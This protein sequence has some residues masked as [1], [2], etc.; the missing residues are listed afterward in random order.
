VLVRD[1]LR[2]GLRGGRR[3]LL[4]PRAQALDGDSERLC[5]LRLRI[6][7][8]GYRNAR[9]AGGGRRRRPAEVAGCGRPGRRLRG[10]GRGGLPRHRSARRSRCRGCDRR[11]RLVAPHGDVA[12]PANGL[13][14]T[15]QQRLRGALGAAQLLD[16]ALGPRSGGAL[17]GEQPLEL[18]CAMLELGDA[19]S[20]RRLGARGCAAVGGGSLL[21]LGELAF[22]GLQTGGE[23]LD[24]ALAGAD[25]TAQPLELAT[26]LAL[27][28]D[29]A[30]FGLDPQPLL[31][32]L[33]LR[34][35]LQLAL[36]RGRGRGWELAR[37]LRRAFGATRDAAGTGRLTGAPRGVEQLADSPSFLLGVLQPALQTRHV[38]LERADG[39]LGGLGAKP[40]RV[41]ARFDGAAGATFGEKVA[42]AAAA[43]TFPATRRVATRRVVSLSDHSVKLRPQPDG[44]GALRG[45]RQPAAR[46]AI[47]PAAPATESPPTAART[48][49]RDEGRRR[50]AYHLA[51]RHTTKPS[52]L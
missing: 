14:E 9:P 34:R 29:E 50:R 23:R 24:V 17:E 47:A 2:A 52:S 42:L 48:S 43:T 10:I 40:Q 28:L 44:S 51:P 7:G 6:A 1:P 41:L 37:T 15:A 12:Q 46:R 31:G 26:R 3:V 19:R 18:V 21:G 27:V 39:R 33:A 20:Q 13:S 25:P 30:L 36:E 16:G 38:G 32:V 8:L 45:A 5:H 35:A 11:W 4:D 22:G 49:L